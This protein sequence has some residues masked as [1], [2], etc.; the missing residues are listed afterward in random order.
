[1]E[2]CPRCDKDTLV[3]NEREPINGVRRYRLFCA[4]CLWE[5]PIEIDINDLHRKAEEFNG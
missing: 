5:S 1:M 4:S 3:R 2:K